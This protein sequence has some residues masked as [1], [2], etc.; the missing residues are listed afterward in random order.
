MPSSPGSSPNTLC[1]V[2]A[3]TTLLCRKPPHLSQV[4]AT[5]WAVTTLPLTDPFPLHTGSDTPCQA[6]P[7]T[8]QCTRLSCSALPNGF[9]IELFR[10]ENE[11][12]KEKKGKERKERVS[13]L[14]W[15]Y[16][17]P[18]QNFLMIVFSIFYIH[19][20]QEALFM[21]SGW[22]LKTGFITILKWTTTEISFK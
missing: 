15:P 21:I 20:P 8:I 2:S 5:T 1:Q 16:T 3:V 4:P 9:F 10:K 6:A 13:Y 7:S 12:T 22:K 18:D 17:I 14:K 11:S 19:H